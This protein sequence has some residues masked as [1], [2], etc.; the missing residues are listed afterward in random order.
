MWR[1]TTRRPGLESAVITLLLIGTLVLRLEYALHYRIDSDEPQHLHVAWGWAHGLIQYRDVF[2]NHAP[3]FHLLCAPLVRMLGERPDIVLLMRFAMF[4][5]YVASL[6]SV[7]AIA[8]AL[9]SRRMA[10][11]ATAIAALAPGFFL[12]SVEFRADDLWAALWL[13]ALAV[14]V[15]GRLTST[16]SF[17]AGVL[18]GATLAV[19]LKTTLLLA[20]L[21]IGSIAALAL[22][23]QRSWRVYAT[24]Y[25][26]AFCG[27]IVV[28]AVIVAAF[29]WQG[30]FG[31][32]FYG[33]VSH[34]TLPGLGLWHKAPWR[35][36]LLPASVLPLWALASLVAR[37]APTPA[38]AARR[39]LVL[40]STS[41]FFVLLAGAWPLITREDLIPGNP[42]V[43]LLLTPVVL[44]LP[45][46]ARR[47]ERFVPAPLRWPIVVPLL[48]VAL[49]VAAAF[50]A[51]SPLEDHTSGQADLVA[52]V[53]QITGPEDYV[54]DLKGETVF[55]HRPYYF[56]LESITKVRLERGLLP[57][58]IPED[59]IATR[60]P[61]VI[62]DRSGFP[63][64]GRAFMAENYL[65]V[66]PLRVLGHMLIQKEGGDSLMAFEVVVPARYAIVVEH[67]AAAGS[68]DGIPYDGA[69][70]LAPGVHEF[71]PDPSGGRFAVMWARAAEQ[72]LSP[73]YEEG[74]SS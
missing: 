59:L 2:D 1:N 50:H 18:L 41:I 62:G 7:Y 38:L 33:T 56:V 61:V 55:R 30:A 57:D 24:H 4:P 53:L 31:P 5:L 11:W 72:G 8:A 29:A 66:G 36:A 71:R 9:F 25:A 37:G 68:L 45:S 63:P 10:A 60:T 47:L 42:L 27:L 58:S 32:L 74:V 16:R 43:A 19:S 34:N 64:R 26:V 6:A 12:T 65:P 23:R 17:V 21:G 73:F 70:L 20:S 22:A 52:S 15:R 13:V 3:L 40:L 39:V 49:E 54:M 35:I 44:A 28:P 51:A 14:L 67:G 69:R 48:V 46:M